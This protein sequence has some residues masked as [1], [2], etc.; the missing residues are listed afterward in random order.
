MAG[1][2]GNESRDTRLGR[3]RREELRRHRLSS[4]EVFASGPFTGLRSRL[5]CLLLLWSVRSEYIR[6]VVVADKDPALFE[7]LERFCQDVTVRSVSED[8]CHL[9]REQL[10]PFLAGLSGYVAPVRTDLV[11]RS[12]RTRDSWDLVVKRVTGHV[13]SFL[14]SDSRGLSG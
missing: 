12:H 7:F 1:T 14:L 2:A 8:D 13:F 6:T 3:S 11:E 4:V 5:V 10:D 9:P